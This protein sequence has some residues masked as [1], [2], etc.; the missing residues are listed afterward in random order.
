MAAAVHFGIATYNAAI[1]EHAEHS[2]ATHKLFPHQWSLAD[3]Y[4]QPGDG[5]GLGVDIDEDLA[6]EF[7]YERAYLPVTRLED[8]TVGDW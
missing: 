6:A 4:L 5:P 8:G 7:P 2:A 3:G 1:Q